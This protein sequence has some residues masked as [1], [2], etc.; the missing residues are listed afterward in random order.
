MQKYLVQAILVF[1]KG[2]GIRILRKDLFDLIDL[3]D[4]FYSLLYHGDKQFQILDPINEKP[5][6]VYWDAFS[7]KNCFDAS[8]IIFP[9]HADGSLN[10]RPSYILILLKLAYSDRNNNSFSKV[11]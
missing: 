5:F 1:L 9:L 7:C 2:S 10:L 6:S 11:F 3:K 4:T 8:N